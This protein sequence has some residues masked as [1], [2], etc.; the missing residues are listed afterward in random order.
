MRNEK[1][2]KMKA[3]SLSENMWSEIQRRH[4]R[5]ETARALS[6]EF[7][8]DHNK[9]RRRVGRDSKRVREMA[10]KLLEVE[11]EIKSLPRYLQIETM[12]LF[13]ELKAVSLHLAGAARYGAMTAH[14]LNKVANDRLREAVDQGRVSKGALSEISRLIEVAGKASGI[15]LNLIS[16]T[17]GLT[18]SDAPELPRVMTKEDIKE[19]LKR[20]GLPTTIFAT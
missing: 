1:L 5:G 2:A 7:N 14:E 16:S 18:P 11:C 6:R 20:R 17:K 12:D 8:V 9:I 15:G 10:E 3:D 4:I 19:E 13:D